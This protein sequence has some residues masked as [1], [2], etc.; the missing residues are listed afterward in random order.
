MIDRERVSGHLK[1]ERVRFDDHTH[2][3]K[4]KGVVK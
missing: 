4:R 1:I 3:K 2:S